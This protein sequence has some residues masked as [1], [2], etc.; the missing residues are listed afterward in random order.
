[1]AKSTTSKPDLS[2]V[3]L[4]ILAPDT[5]EYSWTLT[6]VPVAW[7]ADERRWHGV[8]RYGDTHYLDNL[9]VRGYLN[10]EHAE[11][12]TYSW[13]TEYLEGYSIQVCDAERMYKTLAQV[14]KGLERA[15]EK[16][17]SCTSFGH[18]CLRVA[19]ALGINT[20]IRKSV[21]YAGEYQRLTLADGQYAID[22]IIYT[23]RES[24]K[25]NAAAD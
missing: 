15:R 4:E 16:D 22:N 19:R 2:N 18:Y 12:E 1:M 11:R 6:L 23:W 25:S 8:Y 13:Y 7:N 21:H 14:E 24:L 10:P 20:I 9:Q 5:N 3:A 17:G